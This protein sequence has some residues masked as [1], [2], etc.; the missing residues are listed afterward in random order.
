MILS[1][2]KRKRRRQGKVIETR[3]YYLRFRLGEMPVDR[4]VSLATTDKAVAHVKAK[5]FIEKLEREQAGLTPAPKLVTA[6]NAALSDLCQEY[7]S[8]LEARGGDE[9]YGKGT[10]KRLQS[11]IRECRWP[12]LRDV[13]LESFMVW[14]RGKKL[15]VKT[16]NDYLT[17]V[18]S[19]FGWLVKMDRLGKNP[20]LKVEKIA[21]KEEEEEKRR[22]FKKTSLSGCGR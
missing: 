22:A 15:K 1:I 13:S 11:V 20:L 5:E 18:S 6:A 16:L 17:D 4:W 9:K 8:E 2:Q 14:R 21:R 3:S 19:F 10:A 12:R 7:V